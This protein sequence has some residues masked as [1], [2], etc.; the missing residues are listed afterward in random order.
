MTVL[1][2][3]LGCFAGKRCK[4][5]AAQHGLSLS[6]QA[7][8]SPHPASQ[9]S[10]GSLPPSSAPHGD[11]LQE[12]RCAEELAATGH[13]WYQNFAEQPDRFAAPMYPH[14]TAAGRG[15]GLLQARPPL[16]PFWGLI[17]VPP[18][19]TFSPTSISSYSQ[20]SIQAPAQR[21][22]LLL[23]VPLTSIQ[24]QSHGQCASHLLPQ[25][26]PEVTVTW[27]HLGLPA[28]W[29]VAS[30][31]ELEPLPCKAPTTV[32]MWWYRWNRS[33]KNGH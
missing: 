31:G 21:S 5:G 17:S 15:K 20:H 28:G 10:C 26:Q 22:P 19:V 3:G 23:L 11:L 7:I 32:G 18:L 1:Q 6:I 13:G 25:T 4:Q 33:R 30:T 16:T 12:G 2:P 29:D 27:C 14:P 9:V 24:T 8:P